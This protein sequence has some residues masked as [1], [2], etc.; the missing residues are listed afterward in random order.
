MQ[1]KNI[2]FQPKTIKMFTLLLFS[3]IVSGSQAHKD[4]P[5]VLAV[6][7]VWKVLFPFSWLAAL[8]HFFKKIH[9]KISLNEAFQWYPVEYYYAPIIL[10]SLNLI[11]RSVSGYCIS[12][13]T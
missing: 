11:T 7:S 1:N 10:I 13:Q 2:A 3:W 5:S 4:Y 6:S 12:K 9:T 8:Y